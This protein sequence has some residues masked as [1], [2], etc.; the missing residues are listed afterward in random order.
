MIKQ[1]SP[2]LL[3]ALALI[4]YALAEIVGGSGMLAVAVCGLLAGNIPFKEKPEVK[5][6]EDYMSEMLRIS[7]FTL[8]G[9]QIMFTLD[10][11]QFLM[12]CLFFIALFFFRPVFAVPTLGKKLREELSR[13]D[14]LLVSFVG[15][16]GLAAAAMAPIVATVIISVGQP[17][18]A[19]FILN[20][21][22]LVVLLS[23]LVSSMAAMMLREKLPPGLRKKKIELTEYEEITAKI[24]PAPPP[25][26]P[27]K[28]KRR[29]R[30]AKK[31]PRKKKSEAV[32]A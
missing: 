5:H 2:L 25:K 29:K 21:I 19:N 31:K 7:V 9:A 28:A 20:V 13:R 18:V 12:A 17:D 26:A 1:Y 3:L 10:A 27:R 23:V 11:M 4:T 30:K 24:K 32:A 8:L 15:P 22:F 6:F 14:L 16:R